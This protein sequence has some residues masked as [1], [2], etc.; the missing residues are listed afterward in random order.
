MSMLKWSGDYSLPRLRAKLATT[1]AGTSS[2]PES[3]YAEVYRP[4]LGLSTILKKESPEFFSAVAETGGVEAFARSSG[5]R[6]FRKGKV[7]APPGV[8][9]KSSSLT[10]TQT[11]NLTMKKS[12]SMGGN[13]LGEGAQQSMTRAL[14]VPMLGSRAL[15]RQP[16][17]AHAL[18]PTWHVKSSSSLPGS[19]KAASPDDPKEKQVE[20]ACKKLWTAVHGSENLIQTTCEALRKEQYPTNQAYLAA[21]NKSLANF[22]GMLRAIKSGA[23]IDWHNPEWDGA[24]LLLRAARTGSKDL[25]QF[26]LSQS[27]NIQEKDFSGRGVLHWAALSGNN[28]LVQYLLTSYPE[29]DL[30]LADHSGDCALHLA[31]YAG[32]LGVVRQ[33]VLAGAKETV[34]NS[35]G[36]TPAQLAESKR[37]WH[38]S[39]FLRENQSGEAVKDRLSHILRYVDDSPHGS[40]DN[41]AVA[42]NR[43]EY[44][45]QAKSG[46]D[47]TAPGDLLGRSASDITLEEERLLKTAQELESKELAQ[48]LR[49]QQ[50][51]GARSRSSS[52]HD[53]LHPNAARSHGAPATPQV[54]RHRLQRA[55]RCLQPLSE[56][57]LA[58]RRIGNVVF[59]HSSAWPRL[60]RPSE[61]VAAVKE[62]PPRY[63]V[64]ERFCTSIRRDTFASRW[65]KAQLLYMISRG[66]MEYEHDSLQRSEFG[67]G[68][69]EENA[70][71][72]AKAALW[73]R[74]IHVADPE[75]TMKRMFQKF[76]GDKL[77]QRQKQVS[78]QSTRIAA[79]A[80][81]S[82][83][84]NCTDDTSAKLADADS[85]SSSS[86]SSSK[87][88]KK[89]KKARKAKI[90]KKDKKKHGKEKKAKSEMLV[91]LK[92]ER[93]EADREA[94]LDPKFTKII[95]R[96]RQNVN[97]L[98][99]TK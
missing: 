57:D 53:W 65:S 79:V 78:K 46:F 39:K 83:R 15:E 26:C 68:T 28:F 20:A 3:D 11:V 72:S 34:V 30:A 1:G 42:K 21:L 49:L 12:P 52:R 2:S 45:V 6:G 88:K 44:K 85:G 74:G 75:G 71:R 63:E 58:A 67:K 98:I 13:K 17:N 19:I 51:T 97:S 96:F 10:A 56:K 18:P 35:G 70:R 33:L 9:S 91:R 94:S 8:L 48:T 25:A 24:T 23:K 64:S 16:G 43:G 32:H 99:P 66:F 38:V 31:A 87:K 47:L 55:P 93:K 41:V 81:S 69:L 50:S 40:E 60:L 77:E 54:P 95:D 36:F 82:N 80:S 22:P 14:S 27:A 84:R 76:I 61:H 62:V 89:I 5:Y 4:D 86:S 37:M 59:W 7:V 73:S 92:R 90:K 29:L